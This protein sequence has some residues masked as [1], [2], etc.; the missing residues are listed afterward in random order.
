MDIPTVISGLL[1]SS[2]SLTDRNAI[3]NPQTLAILVRELNVGSEAQKTQRRFF[4][5]PIL[6]NALDPVLGPNLFPV[7]KWIKPDSM[8]RKA[9]FWEGGLHKAFE[10][11]EW[12]SGK[13]LTILMV[14]VSEKTQQT[15][16]SS[17][18]GWRCSSL[19]QAEVVSERGG[20][21]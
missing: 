4:S 6:S 16:A 11:G 12:N 9:G 5:F 17:E 2:S 18:M 21:A 10:D 13:D 7:W 15:I 1:N 14:A 19:E 3:L 8:Y 20:F